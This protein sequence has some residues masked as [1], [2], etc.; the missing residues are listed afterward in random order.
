MSRHEEGSRQMTI[1]SRPTGK[2]VATVVVS[3]RESPASASVCAD[4]PAGGLGNGALTIV[5][6]VSE[7]RSATCEG[8]K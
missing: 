4:I 5:P 1:T 8:I 3:R 2:E 6:D 7:K